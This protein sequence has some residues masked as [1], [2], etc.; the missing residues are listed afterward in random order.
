MIFSVNYFRS[1]IARCP[2]R[3]RI[4]LFSKNSSNSKVSQSEV[5]LRIE[6]QILRLDVPVDNLITMEV[7]KGQKDATDKEFNDM[8]RKSLKSAN[9]V[10]Q[11]SS[12]HV[13]HDQ[14]EIDSIL[15][16]IDHIY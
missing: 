12:R 1:H 5:A 15:K 6:N 8:F 9:L 14:I 2:T 4:V 11:V 16:S 7:L 10:S 3:I 13:I